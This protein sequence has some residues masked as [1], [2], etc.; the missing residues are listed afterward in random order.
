MEKSAKHQRECLYYSYYKDISMVSEFIVG[1]HEISERMFVLFILLRYFNGK[2]IYNW[3]VQDIRYRSREN[4]CMNIKF[5][6]L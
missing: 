4:N 5:L 1:E 6:I 2:W 3:R